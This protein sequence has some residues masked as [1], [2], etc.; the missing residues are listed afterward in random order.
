MGVGRKRIHFSSQESEQ[1]PLAPLSRSNG[2]NEEY[3]KKRSARDAVEMIT[4]LADRE[5][6]ENL[7][8]ERPPTAQRC[9]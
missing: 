4:A 8:R 6:E 1:L 7:S 3:I 9:Q 5:G 2:A